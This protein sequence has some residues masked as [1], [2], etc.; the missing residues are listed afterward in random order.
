MTQA[1][2]PSELLF[3]AVICAAVC[4]GGLAVAEQPAP[5]D[6][7]APEPAPRKP[8]IT[9]PSVPTALPQRLDGYGWMIRLHPTPAAT[10]RDACAQAVKKGVAMPGGQPI[11]FD[12]S[13]DGQPQ[14]YGASV[15]GNP[16]VSMPNPPKPATP[17]LS[18]TAVAAG[19]QL[20]V[21]AVPFRPERPAKPDWISHPVFRP[22]VLFVA[23]S[24]MPSAPLERIVADWTVWQIGRASCRERV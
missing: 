8:F 13:A 9:L 19:L 1:V 16:F 11:V 14:F 23:D 2:R 7:P 5:S 18:Q 10:V 20:P 6:S 24:M 21:I 15:S 3:Q 12:L 17:A 22:G 4:F